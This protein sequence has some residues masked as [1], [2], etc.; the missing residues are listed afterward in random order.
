M[1]QITFKGLIVSARSFTDNYLWP[2]LYKFEPGVEQHF[3]NLTNCLLAGRQIINLNIIVQINI[4]NSKSC[5]RL[6]LTSHLYLEK[7]VT[8]TD[9][10]DE[11]LVARMYTEGEHERF[12]SYS[13]GL[14]TLTK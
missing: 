7:Y 14:L 13:N 1:C 10:L 3:R 4:L 5:K 9:T 11:G 8:F 12:F 6:L 2:T